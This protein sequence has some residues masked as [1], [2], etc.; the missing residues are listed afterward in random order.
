MLIR[1]GWLV[2]R[3]RMAQVGMGT[4]H[5]PQSPRVLLLAALAKRGLEQVSFISVYSA[6]LPLRLAVSSWKVGL[7]SIFVSSTSRLIRHRECCSETS[8][9]LPALSC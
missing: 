9:G 4:G 8:W 6:A 5:P 3:V 1:N 7:D 2:G